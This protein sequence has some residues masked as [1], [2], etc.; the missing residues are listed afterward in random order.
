MEQTRAAPPRIPL[1][2]TPREIASLFSRWRTR[3]PAGSA[4]AAGE[5]PPGAAEPPAGDGPADGPPVATP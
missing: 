2:Q 4:S 1:F 5:A 3:E